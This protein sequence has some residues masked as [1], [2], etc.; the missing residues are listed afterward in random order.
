MV[1]SPALLWSTE[2]MDPPPA[3]GRGTYYEPTQMFRRR[4]PSPSMSALAEHHWRLMAATAYSNVRV[5]NIYVG[6]CMEALDWAGHNMG[7]IIDC[8]H[9]RSSLKGLE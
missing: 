9:R 5:G 3:D 7:Y 1:D 2:D 8:S 6:N 4:H